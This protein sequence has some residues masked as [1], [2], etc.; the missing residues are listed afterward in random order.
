MTSPAHLCSSRPFQPPH[1]GGRTECAISTPRPSSWVTLAGCVAEPSQPHPLNGGNCRW[2]RTVG[3]SATGSCVQMAGRTVGMQGE[4]H[5][6][7]LLLSVFTASSFSHC[8]Q[9]QSVLLSH[10]FEGPWRPGGRIEVGTK[11]VLSARSLSV[12]PQFPFLSNA[13][14]LPHRAAWGLDEV[15]GRRWGEYGCI[16]AHTPACSAEG[17]TLPACLGNPIKMCPSKG[18]REAKRA[19]FQNN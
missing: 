19:R 10:C 15:C 6:P 16:W 11:E 18:F 17:V 8:C 1:A 13:P 12:P 4:S 9:L 7:W 3:H 14:C 5:P 2:S